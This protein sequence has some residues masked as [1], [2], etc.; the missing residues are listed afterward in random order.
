VRDLDLAPLGVANRAEA[1]VGIVQEPEYGA[2]NARHVSGHRQDLLFAGR[3]G[4]LSLTKEVLEVM[5]P[6]GRGRLGQ[7]LL[8]ALPTE[9]EDFRLEERTGFREPRSEA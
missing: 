6:E 1:K 9:R 4:V 7:N 8:E 5:A 3:E 2:W